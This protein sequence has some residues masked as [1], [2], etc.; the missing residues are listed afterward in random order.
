MRITITS[1]I[2]ENE[3]DGSAVTASWARE[4]IA[5]CESLIV[6]GVI[7]W[8]NVTT[9]APDPATIVITADLATEDV[10]SEGEY[11]GDEVSEEFVRSYITGADAYWLAPGVLRA[12]E[13][14]FA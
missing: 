1:D 14:T 13:V 10:V 5:G 7:S 2:L 8:D 11:K 6:P 3:Y 4:Y 12:S 9:T